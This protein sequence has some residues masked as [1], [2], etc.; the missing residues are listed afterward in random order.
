MLLLYSERPGKRLQYIAKILLKDISGIDVAFTQSRDEFQL[1][2]GAKINYSGSPVA[3][4]EIWI[5]PVA[6]LF[7]DTIAHQDVRVFEV[8]GHKAFFGTD[9]GDFPFD[10]FASSFYLLSRY[11]EYLPHS[12]DEYDR[13]AHTNSLAFRENFL[14]QPLVNIWL[15][16]FKKLL[17]RKN[18]SLI[19]RVPKFRFIPTYDIDV[20]YSYL[21]KGLAR[22]VRGM[23]KS[24][25]KGEISALGERVRVLRGKTVDPYDV[26]EWLYALHL[27]YGL[28]PYYFFLVAK[29]QKGVDKN[30]EPTRDEML[31]LIRY[32]AVGYT[33][34][35]HPSWQ[36]GDDDA[37]LHEEIALLEF[38][39][40]K[41]ITISRQ[42]Y[43]RFELPHTFRKLIESGIQQ[44]FSM[45]YG[46][47]NGFRASVASPYPWY[48]LE[49]EKK[50]NLVLFPFCF[51]DANSYY[52][53]KF[54]PQQAY[55]EIKY[56]HDAVKKVNGTMISI[57]HNQFFSSNKPFEGWKE[58]YEL[59]IKEVLYW[60]L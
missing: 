27:K 26:Y 57:W 41:P 13:Y 2:D 31:E 45:G 15:E 52:E 23:L 60:D 42:H 28:K 19:W 3:G 12:K 17:K 38:I 49:N 40:N 53:Q 48:D 58:V 43:I 35:V 39:T 7:E 1:F 9:A 33:V 30:I 22:N 21:S 47:I 32:H 24:L 51:M 14:S 8:N 46:S 44:E 10:I 37:L 11:E 18:P 59:F 4:K 36:S 29:E 56:Y 6:L 16:D 20:A 5:Y 34:G 25:I 54:T 50:T 55:E